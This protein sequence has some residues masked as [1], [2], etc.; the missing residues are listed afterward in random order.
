M[1]D[2]MTTLLITGM[3]CGHCRM[4]VKE[5]LEKVPGVLASEVDL[6]SGLAKVK[7]EALTADLI[8]AV[9]AEGYGAKAVAP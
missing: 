7:G 8:A 4:H 3:T 2:S 6:S 9:E 5:A 1:G